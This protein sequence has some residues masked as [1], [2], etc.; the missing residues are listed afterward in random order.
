[1]GNKYNKDGTLK[2]IEKRRI[3]NRL[4]KNNLYVVLLCLFLLFVYGIMYYIDEKI[5]EIIAYVLI[6]IVI[7]LFVGFF[8]FFY[9]FEVD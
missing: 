7:I 4:N 5:L 8:I 3:Q 2:K 6:I 1:M 9:L